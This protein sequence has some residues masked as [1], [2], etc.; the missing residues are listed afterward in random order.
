MIIHVF[1]LTDYHSYNFERFLS[2]RWII[3]MI[4]VILTYSFIHFWWIFSPDRLFWWLSGIFTI[5]R[6]A[7]SWYIPLAMGIALECGECFCWAFKELNEISLIQ[8]RFGWTPEIRWFSL[9]FQII[10]RGVQG[11]VFADQLGSWTKLCWCSDDSVEHLRS[12]DFS[13]FFRIIDTEVKRKVFVDQL[14]NQTK[15]VLIIDP[16]ALL[17]LSHLK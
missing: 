17:D 12:D 16:E 3:L 14:K 7:L 5:L 13:L 9:F 11:K 15:F 10:D 6:A 4:F 2:P 1:D 8:W